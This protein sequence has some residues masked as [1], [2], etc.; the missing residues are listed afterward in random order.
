V[1]FH[2]WWLIVAGILSSQAS[3]DRAAPR[4][5]TVL[6]ME[7]TAYC[8]QGQ[9][10]SGVQ[11]RRGVVAADPRVLPLGSRVRVDGLG[12]PHDRVYDVEDTGRE[13]KGRELDVFMPDCQAAKVFGRQMALVRILRRGPLAAPRHSRVV[14]PT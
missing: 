13:I 10:A 14:P 11:T 12:R 7:V 6:E 9:T 1:A 5:A 8:S 3:A 4:R 2:G